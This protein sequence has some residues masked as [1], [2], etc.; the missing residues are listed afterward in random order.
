MKTLFSKGLSLTTLAG[1]LLL[2][3]GW[4]GAG[5]TTRVSV[6]S[7]GGQ[8]NDFSGAA[9]SISVDTSISADGRFVVFQ[10]DAT[11]LVAGDTNGASDVFVHDR[12]TGTT[13]RVSVD[14]AG[15]EATGLYPASGDPAISADGRFV[16][17]DSNATNLVAGDTN[18]AYDIFVHDR[19]TGTTTRV[20]VDS[21][22]NQANGYDPSLS[23]DGRFVAFTSGASNLVAGDTN[24][25]SDVFVHDRQTG[26]T[27]RVSVDS[28]GWQAYS[29]SHL[30]S[31]S[32]DGRFVA[33]ASNATNLVA[34]FL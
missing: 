6:D 9:P 13:T 25:A 32:A 27:T 7:A 12:Q 24:G 30:P 29:F 8:A 18:S 20:S 31:I 10:S 19:Q 33:F 21:A 1:W 22:G 14:S 5:T 34:C 3:P 11:N 4:A 28:A 23:A 2:A 26:T 16:A 17:F 15:H